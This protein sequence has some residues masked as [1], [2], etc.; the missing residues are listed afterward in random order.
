MSNSST[1]APARRPGGQGPRGRV[2][3]LAVLVG[4][5]ALVATGSSGDRPGASQE[6]PSWREA[7]DYTVG[8]GTYWWTSNAAYLKDGDVAPAYG[9]AWVHGYGGTSVRGCLF[10]E[11][12]QGPALQWEFFQGWDPARQALYSWQTTQTGAIGAGY[13]APAGPGE[14]EEMEQTFTWPDGTE[15]RVKHEAEHVHRDTMVT[16]SFNWVDGAWQPRRTYTWV[17]RTG[18]A[19]DLCPNLAGAP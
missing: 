1:S 18:D 3:A 15:V 5:G 9:T 17:R 13:G 2:A 7:F 16:R 19:L 8:D 6:T 10:A 12:E 14:T 4:L 11:T